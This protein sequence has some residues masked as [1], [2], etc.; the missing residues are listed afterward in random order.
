MTA[1]DYNA[2]MGQVAKGDQNAFRQLAGALGQKMFHLA[3]RLMGYQRAAA[4]DAVQEALI[5]IWKSAPN[6]QPTGSVQAYAS[7]LV[8]TS[9]MDI[10]RRQRPTEELP[11]EVPQE[12]TVLNTILDREQR[13]RLLGA[14]EQLPGRQ[15]DAILLHY[16]DEH[17]QR[18]IAQMMGTTEK[19]IER[20]LARGRKRLREI[21]PAEAA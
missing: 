17:S 16:M 11:E 10:H 6:W 4:E 19:G 3:Y 13:S 14:I 5:K 1:D 2:L 8:Y 12:D 20:L 18:T 7:R 9:C 15:K 21:L